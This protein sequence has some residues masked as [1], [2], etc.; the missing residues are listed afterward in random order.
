MIS[1][2]LILLAPP[3]EC[4]QSINVLQ[5]VTRSTHLHDPVVMRT[6]ELGRPITTS[7]PSPCL[8][9]L[10]IYCFRFRPQNFLVKSSSIFSSLNYTFPLWRFWEVMVHLALTLFSSF[11]STQEE[12]LTLPRGGGGDN[13]PRKKWKEM[14]KK[15]FTHLLFCRFST[16]I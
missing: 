8:F 10:F 2:P 11:Y 14:L 12:Y 15:R 4:R 9:H 6:V 3:T 16:R 5:R 7:G 1:L 13:S